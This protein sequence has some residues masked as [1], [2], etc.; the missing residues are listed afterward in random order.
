MLNAFQHGDHIC[1][2]YDTEEEQLTTAA[3]Y[4]ADGIGRGE[5]GLY[6]AESGD[7]LLRFR[8]ALGA[9]G[10]DA[11][12]LSARGVLIELTYAEAYLAGGR[13]DA[14]R[15]LKMV[16]DVIDQALADGF[17]GLR[18]CG[19]MS[20]LLAGAPGSGQVG[21]YEARLNRVFSG[22]RA[23]ALCQYNR[24]RLPPSEIDM[25]LITHSTA[26]VAGQ[27]KFNPFFQ[28]ALPSNGKPGSGPASGT[29][30]TTGR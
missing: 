23:G 7:A 26:V 15:M 10:L 9:I 13:F 1:S 27:L 30:L 19:D 3:A 5:R 24:K 18:A 25:A 2:I 17:T 11:G 21:E 22:A 6:A 16:S 28:N 14:E 12:A 29:D 20:W 4:I 8:A